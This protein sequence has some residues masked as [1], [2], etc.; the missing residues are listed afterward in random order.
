MSNVCVYQKKNRKFSLLWPLKTYGF[1]YVALHDNSEQTVRNLLSHCGVKLYC[2]KKSVTKYH[3][4]PSAFLLR[5]LTTNRF[6]EFFAY[7][8]STL[9]AHTSICILKQELYVKYVFVSKPNEQTVIM[10]PMQRHGRSI[11]SEKS[12]SKS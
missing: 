7:K 2:C 6:Y 8:Y 9:L 12:S 11:F 3:R 10:I 5:C 4:F 1:I